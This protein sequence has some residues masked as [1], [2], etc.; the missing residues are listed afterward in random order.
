M[1]SLK[2]YITSF[3][4]REILQTNNKNDAM[5]TVQTL[6]RDVVTL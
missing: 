5:N 6:P 3:T 1:D 2:S 4:K